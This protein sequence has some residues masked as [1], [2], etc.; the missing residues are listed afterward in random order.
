MAA[1]PSSA[2]GQSG[3]VVADVH[4]QRGDYR[5]SFRWNYVVGVVLPGRFNEQSGDESDIELFSRSGIDRLR[6][7]AGRCFAGD[8]RL[9]GID[10]GDE[11]ENSGRKKWIVIA[12]LQIKI[13]ERLFC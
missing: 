11:N 6:G 10:A 4:C 3:R 9:K 7:Q 5:I 1:G 13:K 2:S 12:G 8:S